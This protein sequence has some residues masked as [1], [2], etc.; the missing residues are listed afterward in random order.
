MPDIASITVAIA[1]ASILGAGLFSQL[2]THRLRRRCNIVGLGLEEPTTGLAT[3]AAVPVMFPAELATAEATGTQ[4]AVVAL[5]MLTLPPEHLGRDIAD[6]LRTHEYGYRVD[7]D[8]FAV[9]VAVADRNEAVMAGARIATTIAPH[10]GAEL[11]VG[12]AMCPDDTTDFL[13]AVDI[14]CARMRSVKVVRAVAQELR[15]SLAASA[16][17]AEV[18][19]AA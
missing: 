8:L 7:Y 10:A 17:A 6:A 13:D 16:S 15:Q 9:C 4:L 18:Q 11:R 14:A 1:G 2:R 3:L 5:R 19:Q 12:I